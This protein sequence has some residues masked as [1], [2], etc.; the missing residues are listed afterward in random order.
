M[1]GDISCNNVFLDEEATLVDLR[2]MMNSLSSVIKR[3]TSSP[4][5]KV[6]Q[7]KPRSSLLALPSMRL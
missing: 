6:F 5:K 2:L 3:V 4:I 7:T 1:H